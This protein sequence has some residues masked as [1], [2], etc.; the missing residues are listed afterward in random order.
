MSDQDN[1]LRKALYKLIDDVCEEHAIWIE[2]R[3]RLI[4]VPL[5]AR[6][7]PILALLNQSR[8]P[9]FLENPTY[10][11]AYRYGRNAL[12]DELEKELSL[13][14]QTE[15][16]PKRHNRFDDSDTDK[17]WQLAETSTFRQF[18]IKLR[19]TIW[20]EAQI[21]ENELRDEVRNLLESKRSKS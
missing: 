10:E 1:E 5:E 11:Q 20:K 7:K 18:A 6:L 17:L 2:S 12:L 19:N 14:H 21:H 8:K 15:F 4:K 9:D 13:E 3:G 16:I